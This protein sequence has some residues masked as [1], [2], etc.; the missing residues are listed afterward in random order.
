LYRAG[1]ADRIFHR[2]VVTKVEFGNL[3]HSQS[4][5]EVM[6]DKTG[7]TS[8]RR[9]ILR[10]FVICTEDAYVNVRNPKIRRHFNVGDTHETDAGILDLPADDIDKLL[11]KELTDLSRSPTHSSDLTGRRR[12]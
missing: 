5:F 11:F 8:Q 12:A 10:S 6:P 2:A 4:R 7:G 1:N 3:P 9:Q